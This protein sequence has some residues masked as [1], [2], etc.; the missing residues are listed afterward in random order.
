MIHPIKIVIHRMVDAIWS[1][2][3]EA[4]DRHS[5]E[6]EKDRMIGATADA[7]I[8]ERRVVYSTSS[9]LFSFLANC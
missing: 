9:F 5:D 6:V 8:H 3:T 4:D 2:K 1:L 7:S